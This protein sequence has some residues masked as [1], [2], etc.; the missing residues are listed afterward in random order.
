MKNNAYAKHN[1]DYLSANTINTFISQPAMA[2]LKLWGYRSQVGASAWRGNAIDK[3]L[4]TALQFDDMTIEVAKSNAEKTFN[5]YR[6]DEDIDTDKIKKELSIT[7]RCIEKAFEDLL[8]E[9]RSKELIGSQGK[10]EVMLDDVPVPFIGYYDWLFEDK[11][12]DL[13]SKGQRTSKPDTSHKRQL[14]LYEKGT[15]KKP[16]VIYVSP[17]EIKEFS[18]DDSKDHLENMRTASL[19]LEKIL[20]FSDDIQECCRLLYPDFDHWMW[21]EQDQLEAKKIWSI[22]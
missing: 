18:I 15:G 7:E 9:Y 16:Y 12:V 10:I 5:T 19:A 1:I 17:N 11:V 8:P 4:T 14:A 21:S 22:K 2:L 20:S 13:K 6:H 3:T